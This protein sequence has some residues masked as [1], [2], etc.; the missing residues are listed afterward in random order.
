LEVV[1]AELSTDGN[2]LV[3]HLSAAEKVEGIHGDQRAPLSAVRRRGG[4]R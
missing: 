4:A 3:L 2:E 1:M